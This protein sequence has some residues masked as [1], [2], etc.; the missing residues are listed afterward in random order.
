M[1][2]LIVGDTVRVSGARGM[3]DRQLLSDAVRGRLWHSKRLV[4]LRY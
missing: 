4:W 2:K 1:D 3:K